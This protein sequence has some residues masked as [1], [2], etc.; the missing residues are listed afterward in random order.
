M[1][2]RHFLTHPSL[3]SVLPSLG[4][5]LAL[6][7]GSLATLPAGALAQDQPQ[8]RPDIEGPTWQLLTYR[9]AGG[10]MLPVPPGIVAT[11]LLFSNVISGETACSTYRSTYSLRGPNL[12]I[13]PPEVSS[14]P[15]DAEGQAID[16]AFY[17]G[18]GSTAT[19]TIDGSI[20]EL[21]DEVAEPILTF[22]RANLPSDPTIAPWELARIM[23]DDGSFTSVIQ[24]TSP[25][26]QFLRGGRVVGQ[27]GCG[28]FLGDYA[29]NGTEMRVTDIDSVRGAC[30]D[31]LRRQ[32]DTIIQTLAEVTDFDVLPAGLTLED[33]SGTTRMALVPEI[34]LQA[35]TRWT[36]T[37]IPG[38]DGRSIVN[39][40]RLV[41]SSL[42]VAPGPGGTA[43]RADGRSYCRA[44]DARS[45]RSGLA[46][47]IFRLTPDQDA[48]CPDT[49][50]RRGRQNPDRETPLELE[51]AFLNALEQAASHALRGSE[52]E[53]MDAEGRPVMRLVP[54]PELVGVP[55]VLE[56][57]DRTP[58][59]QNPRLRPPS[60]NAV[61]TATFESIDVVQGETGAG[62]DTYSAFYNRPGA[63]TI[64]ITDIDV[65]GRACNNSTKRQKARCR[66]ERAFINLLGQADGFIV[67][68][69]PDGLRLLRGDRTVMTFR[70]AQLQTDPEEE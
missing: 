22:T 50:G 62:L 67:L 4:L 59:R 23:V 31:A 17:R 41:T 18:L 54:Q 53:L 63:S 36:P 24:G 47:S 13:A 69:E 43:G 44:Y 40:D 21:A 27:T 25:S 32:S 52:L 48:P 5:A 26:V 58:G 65:T 12:T 34:T 14:R 56:T 57:I 11:A 20:L 60:A 66:Q 29:T 61:I 10:E 46:V 16:E 6:L 38:P 15:C 30:T 45:L 35:N 49:V 55:W 51:D 64:E 19:W 1:S 3:R 33:A 70:P 28:W 68:P 9:D 42:R 8:G 37:S 2:H 39:P 7:A